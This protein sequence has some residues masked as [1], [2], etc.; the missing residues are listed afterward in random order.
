[1]DVFDSAVR[2]ITEADVAVRWDGDEQRV[3]LFIFGKL[4]AAFDVTGGT[5]HGTRYGTSPNA[6]I[7]WS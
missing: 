1:M 2:P 6:D 7:P 5:K 4:S 3:G